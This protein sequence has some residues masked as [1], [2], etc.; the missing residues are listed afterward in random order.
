MRFLLLL[1]L[2]SSLFS[3]DF[4]VANYN[5]E[6]LFDDIKQGSEYN[7]Y[8]PNNQHGWNSEMFEAKL[9][10]TAEVICDLNADIIALEEIENSY[11]LSRLKERLATVG[12]VYPFDAITT[13]KDAPIQVALLSKFKIIDTDEIVV[14]RSPRVRN[15]LGVEVSIDGYPLKIFV[16][17]WKSRANNGQE[18]KRISYAYALKDYIKR[19]KKQDEYIIIGDFNSGYDVHQTLEKKFNDTRGKTALGD[20]M[21][22]IKERVLVDEK[23]LY[24]SDDFLHYNLWNEL[25]PK[26]RWNYQFRRERF[27]ID[28]ILIPKSMMDSQGID[29]VNDSFFVF[30]PPYLFDKYGSIDRWR[31]IKG[32]HTPYGYSDHLPIAAKFSTKPYVYKEKQQNILTEHTIEDLYGVEKL[33]GSALL[34]NVSVI[35]KRGYHA[36]IKQDSASRGIFLFGCANGLEEGKRY[37]MTVHEIKSYGG[38]KEIIHITTIPKGDV[39]SIDRYYQTLDECQ[40]YN[41]QNEVFKNIKGVYENG[42]LIT[43]C[44]IFSI[45]FKNGIIPPENGDKIKLFYAHLGYYKKLELIVYDRSDFIYLEE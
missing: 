34:K 16:N 31:Y 38:L 40:F 7:D 11:V 9:N 26:E 35:Y 5:V 37:D 29:Y 36:V 17:H 27:T 1:L 18:S 4:T 45:F 3:K 19:L 21:A 32:R 13:K 25:Q 28:H 2:V 33:S 15:I 6:N 20:V 44:G 10:H 14:N 24:D 43:K 22:T 41:R 8:T 23:I 39:V 30:K 12:C 42:R